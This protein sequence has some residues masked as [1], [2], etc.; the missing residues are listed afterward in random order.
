LISAFGGSKAAAE[1]LLHVDWRWGYGIWTII[2]PAFALPVYLLLA[3][4][5]RQAQ[6]KGVITRGKKKWSINLQSI[7]WVV[8]EFDCEYPITDHLVPTKANTTSI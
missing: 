7:W 6:K 4:N 3:Y 1:F 8:T 5:L 2:L